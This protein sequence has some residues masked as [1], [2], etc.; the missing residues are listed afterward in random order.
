MCSQNLF[1]FL[2][3]MTLFN[4]ISCAVE[5]K[6]KDKLENP[7]AVATPAKTS[8][9]MKSTEKES[10]EVKFQIKGSTSP[11]KYLVELSWLPVDGDVRVLERGVLK[12]FVSGQAGFFIDSNLSGGSQASYV[13]EHID[14]EGRVLGAA[15]QV[16]EIPTD[17]LLEG[18]ISLTASR[19]FE[20]HRVFLSRN[21]VLRTFHHDLVII[22]KELWSDGGVIG[23]FPTDTVAAREGNGRHG[24]IITI[25]SEKAMGS[26]RLLLNGEKGGDGKDGVLSFPGKHPG[27]AGSNGGRGGNSGSLN[28]KFQEGR[29]FVVTTE[30]LVG[31]AG[32]A[33]RRGF[34]SSQTPSSL[35]VHPPCH[36]DAP[37]GKEGQAGIQGQICLQLAHDFPFVCK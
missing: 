12:G 8:E 11:H 24:G 6:E 3:G 33:G 35:A 17:L 27:C 29:Q 4:T 13:V 23:N 7:P 37:E 36:R 31:G 2:L 15:S 28:L 34:V 5:L 19:K 14:S 20:A 21:L 22:T 16:I 30:V 10:F 1:V 18:E 32:K 9:P 25:F 26:L